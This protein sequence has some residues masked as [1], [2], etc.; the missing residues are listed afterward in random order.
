M[1]NI[2]LHEIFFLSLTIIRSMRVLVVSVTLVGLVMMFFKL[3]VSRMLDS[4]FPLSS[5]LPLS[6]LEFK[7]PAISIFFLVKQIC[8]SN[9]LNLSLKM[10]LIWRSVDSSKE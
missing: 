9:T 5:L 6:T 7:S 10:V 3:K 1:S 4:F 8:S 2:P